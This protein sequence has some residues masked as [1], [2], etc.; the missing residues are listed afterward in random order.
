MSKSYIEK[1]VDQIMSEKEFPLNMAMACCWILGNFKGIN[2]KLLDVSKNSSL[3]D[4]YI[5]ASATNPTQAQSMA[6]EIT[7]QMKRKGHPT[8]SKEGSDNDSEWVLL[9]LRDIIVHIF[10]E[11]SRPV[12]DLDNLWEDAVAV[13]IPHSYYFSDRELAEGENAESGDSS[14]VKKDDDKDYF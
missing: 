1:N 8:T 14:D 2:L 6:E 12:Y 3:A 9:D 11:N 10:Q 5:L 13:E 7:Y 4:Y